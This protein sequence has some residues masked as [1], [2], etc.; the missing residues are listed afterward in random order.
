MC[1]LNC[2]GDFNSYQLPSTFSFW[3][4]LLKLSTINKNNKEDIGHCFLRGNANDVLLNDPHKW[5]HASICTSTYE[6][7]HTGYYI[8]KVAFISL[9]WSACL[10]D[11]HGSWYICLS[12]SH[13][14]KAH[15]MRDHRI[16]V[17]R[18]YYIYKWGLME[19]NILVDSMCAGAYISENITSTNVSR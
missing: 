18:V 9:G 5:I 13:T 19:M 11:P 6:Y 17:M 4:I 2:F 8:F 10:V 1:N 12:A 7:G 16:R 14:S 3:I 15:I